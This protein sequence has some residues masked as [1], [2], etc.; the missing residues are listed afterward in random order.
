[1]D[2]PVGAFILDRVE[3]DSPAGIAGIRQGD[4]ILSIGGTLITRDTP[5]V[6]ALFDFV[7]GDEVDVVIKRGNGELTVSVELGERPADLMP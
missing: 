6:E 5:F 7:P 4:I 2:E 1:M 3:P